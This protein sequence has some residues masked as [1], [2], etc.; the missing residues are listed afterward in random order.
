MIKTMET[1]RRRSHGQEIKNKFFQSRIS[2]LLFLNKILTQRSTTIIQLMTTTILS[3][4]YQYQDDVKNFLPVV[5]ARQTLHI[6]SCTTIPTSLI[7]SFRSTTT[8]GDIRR[9]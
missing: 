1:P 9:S 8:T 2:T 4:A 7:S 3:L 5:T 6:I